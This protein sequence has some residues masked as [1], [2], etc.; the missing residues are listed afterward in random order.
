[1]WIC[2]SVLLFLLSFSGVRCWS[3][4]NLQLIQ[5]FSH[6]WHISHNSYIILFHLQFLPN[7]AFCA[8]HMYIMCKL[9]FSLMLVHG[10]IS[11]NYI[12]VLKVVCHIF[13]SSVICKLNSSVLELPTKMNKG[14]FFTVA[15][16][17]CSNKQ[18]KGQEQLRLGWKTHNK[19]LLPQKHGGKDEGR[20]AYLSLHWYYSTCNS[21]AHA[22]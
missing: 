17:K 22:G 8:Y 9:L 20:K 1:M 18:I 15:L 21:A 10:T 19:T 4:Y 3:N 12:Y 11:L 5:W 14:E 6:F 2:W 16:I 7:S 13:I